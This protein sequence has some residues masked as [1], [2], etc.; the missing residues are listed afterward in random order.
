MVYTKINLRV[1]F[2]S[3]RNGT[4]IPAPADYDGDR[5]TD[6]AVF[7]PFEATWYVQKSTTGFSS[8]QFGLTDDVPTPADYDGDGKADYAVYRPSNTTWYRF[9]SSNNAFVAIFFGANGDIPIPAFNIV[10]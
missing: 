10:Q 4:D 8:F 7:R 1:L 2:F 9:N 5:Q 3:I 6:I